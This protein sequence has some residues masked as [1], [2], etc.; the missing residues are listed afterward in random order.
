MAPKAA[1]GGQ[2]A[3]RGS[4][5]ASGG[6]ARRGGAAASSGTPIKG[7]GRRVSNDKT[8]KAAARAERPDVADLQDLEDIEVPE[9]SLT[10]EEG[11]GPDELSQGGAPV[12]KRQRTK[13][14]GGCGS[15]G[16]SKA[17]SSSGTGLVCDICRDSSAP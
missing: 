10:V 5:A 9:V 13:G 4:R 14:P 6:A 7:G 15:L 2:V 16:A 1:R 17:A 3:N 8:P 12:A 11:S